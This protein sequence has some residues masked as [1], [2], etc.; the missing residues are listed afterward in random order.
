MEKLKI[1]TQL[2]HLIASVAEIFD[3]EDSDNEEGSAVKRN[4]QKSK[5]AI[6]KTTTRQTI[7]LPVIGIVD[8]K[9]LKPLEL[10]G[11][12]KGT[13]LIFEKLPAEYDSRVKVMEIDEKPKEEY[14]DIGGLGNF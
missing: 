10:V 5:G 14:N 1:N 4:N 12:N 13:Y 2:P 6:I 7:F 11:V 3:L 9:E 8:P